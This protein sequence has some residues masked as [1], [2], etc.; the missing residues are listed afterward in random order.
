MSVLEEVTGA[1]RCR[2]KKK[3]N[4]YC[5]LEHEIAYTLTKISGKAVCFTCHSS[6]FI[7]QN[8]N[9]RHHY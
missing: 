6:V 8:Y 2:D 7:K 4:F 1:Q 9:I 5:R 3:K